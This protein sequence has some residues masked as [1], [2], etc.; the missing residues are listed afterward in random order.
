MGS[1]QRTGW[2][3]LGAAVVLSAMMLA[4]GA[5]G[6]WAKGGSFGGGGGRSFGGGGSRSFGGASRS[7]GGSFGGSVSRAPSSSGGSFGGSA[8]RTPSTG[9]GSFGGAKPS[10]G[11]SSSSSGGSFGAARSS[12]SFGG[13][14]AS[15]SSSTASRGS[16]GS[17]GRSGSMGSGGSIR[18]S[19]VQPRYYGRP[20]T[21]SRTVVYNGM[22]VPAYHYGFWSGYSM[23]WMTPRWYYY[24][25]FHPAFYYGRPVYYEGGIYPGEFSFGRLVIGLCALMFVIWLCTL[26]FRLGGG[27]GVRYTNYS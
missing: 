18:T 27:R 22:S 2:R 8:A 14:T 16:F 26:P 3:R 19:T 12:G 4:V 25:P 15:S 1:Q 23:G 11:S 13:G 10:A 9:G 7:S 5:A 17:F 24:T 20:S 6:A 21:Y